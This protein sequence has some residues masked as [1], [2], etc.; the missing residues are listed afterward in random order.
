MTE[1]SAPTPETSTTLAGAKQKMPVWL[2]RTILVAAAVVILVILY[3]IAS[4]T[5][6]LTWANSI[7]SQ[8]GTNMGNAIP[9]GMFY[10]F[11]FSFVPVIV[12]WQAHYKKLN[13]WVR[14]GIVVLAVILTTP[15]LLTLSVLYGT[16][17]TAKNALSIWNTGG[18]NWFGTWSQIF[19]VAGVICAIAV[20]IL[21]NVWRKRGKKIREVRAAEK[22]VADNEAAKAR[23]AKD[24]A[25]SAEKAARE[26]ARAADKAARIAARGHHDDSPGT[27]SN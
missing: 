2:V 11:V 17:S 15:N 19:M 8:V 21:T 27:P 1:S 25:R 6:P 3:V 7:K 12:A 16:T 5:V 24:A 14:V 23:A 26:D 18:A 13:K 20:I 10:G 4:L 9:L 22:V